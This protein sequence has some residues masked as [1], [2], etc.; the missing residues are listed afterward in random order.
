MADTAPF[1]MWIGGRPVPAAEG[2]TFASYE[3]AT[4]ARLAD[5]PRATSPDVRAAVRAARAA[6]DDGPW[7]RLPARERAAVLRRVAGRLA[8][9]SAR[10]AELEVRDTG[11][12][13]RKATRVD[14]AGAAAAF[15]WCAWWAES[16]GTREPPGPAPE[17]L[18][19]R[20]VGVVAAITPWNFPLLLAASRV[21]P[22]IAAGNACVLKPASFTSLT[23][24]EL[25]RLAHEAGLP[26]GVLNV[27]TGPGAAVGDELARSPE[28]DLV[29]LTGSD[30]VGEQVRAAAAGAVRLDLG[31]KSANVVLDDADLDLAAS[32]ALWGCFFHNGQICMA[33][34]RLIA[35]DRVYD[36]L[37]ALIAKRAP[38]LRLGDPLDPAT[39]LGPLITRQQAR[40]VRRHV[41]AAVAAGAALRCGGDAPG[42]LPAGLD[43]AAYVRPAVLADVAPDS[44]AAQ[45]EIFGPVL[46]VI[47]VRSDDEAVAVANGTRYGLSAAVW[48]GD[49][50]RAAGVAERLR[51]DTVWINDYRMVDV[52]RPG[53]AGTAT[54]RHWN[55]LTNELDHYRRRQRV[56]ATVD[57]GRRRRNYDLLSGEI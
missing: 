49:P 25:G 13:I 35:A 39:D 52:T 32:G 20:P 14:V 43:A 55:R 33:A 12:T 7:P 23:S 21:A 10:L 41:Q 28:V 11:S 48:S 34:A 26:P 5:V 51:A 46:S 31:G 44:A 50:R 30:G 19:W 56:D 57:A 8:A 47:R 36:E 22:A 3:P 53:A 42:A 29:T 16:L 4:G 37:V 9:E 2:E 38:L 27:V 24:L 45:E 6:F 1:P 18:H 40:T 54:D 15:E 17:Y